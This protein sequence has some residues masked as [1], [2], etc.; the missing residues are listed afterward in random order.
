MDTTRSEY[1]EVGPVYVARLLADH[2]LSHQQLGDL[3]GVTRR[4]VGHWKSGTYPVPELVADRMVRIDTV[5]RVQR[6]EGQQE[7]PWPR[8][9]AAAAGALP[10]MLETTC[11]IDTC[12]ACMARSYGAVVAHAAALL[13]TA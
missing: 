9:R 13:A 10:D 1:P 7:C 3:L 2:H 11:H 6:G 5:L 12:P 4:A 8:E